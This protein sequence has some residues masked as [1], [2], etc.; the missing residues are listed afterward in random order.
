MNNIFNLHFTQEE[1]VNVVLSNPII[2]NELELEL[3]TVWVELSR[4]GDEAWEEIGEGGSDNV[5]KIIVSLPKI[6]ET[7][8]RNKWQ[9]DEIALHKLS[10]IIEDIT[11]LPVKE[12]QM[13]NDEEFEIEFLNP[14]PR[15][16]LI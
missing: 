8:V 6:G 15:P 4:Y 1:L 13:V 2:F 16:K 10:Q 14:I 3:V 5:R 7:L 9:E 12:L 11:G